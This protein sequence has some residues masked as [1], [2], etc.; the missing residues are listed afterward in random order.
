MNTQ[1]YNKM[2]YDKNK[3]RILEKMQE[4]T[5]CEIC[6][7]SVSKS[8]MNRHLKTKKCQLIQLKQNEKSEIEKLQNRINELETKLLL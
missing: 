5:V 8:H 1:E 7:S 3:Q 6:N 4:K 2:Y